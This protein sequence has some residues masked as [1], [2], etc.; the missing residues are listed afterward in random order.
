MLSIFKKKRKIQ[1]L[2]FLSPANQYHG[3]AILM[4]AIEISVSYGDTSRTI[5]CL[6][7]QGS[8]T[9]RSGSEFSKAIGRDMLAR[10][11]VVSLWFYVIRVCVSCSLVPPGAWFSL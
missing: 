11:L 9:A 6:S 1:V 4:L 7:L 8:L 10:P 3:P 2:S 5:Y